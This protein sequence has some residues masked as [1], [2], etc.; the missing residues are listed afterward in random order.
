MLTIISAIRFLARQGLPLRGSYVSSDGCETN[1]NFLQLLHLCKEDIPVLYTWL[2][3]SQDRYTSPSIQNELLEIMA[4]MILRKI[5][6]SLS[7]KQ[8]SIMVDETSNISNTEQL[9]FCLRYVDEDLTKHEEFIGLYDMD[10]TTAENVIQDILLRL[11]LQMS[12]CRG[13][14]YDCAGSMAGCRTGVATTIEQQEP[15]ATSPV[16]AL[17]WT[18]T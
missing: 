3:R 9:V 18:R 7:G 16:H 17:L 8:F 11:S 13:Q 4:N 15:G 10:S 1:S 2:Q 5:K 14:C 6:I 12:S